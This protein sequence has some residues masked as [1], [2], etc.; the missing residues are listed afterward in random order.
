[1]VEVVVD[2]YEELFTSCQPTNFSDLI[3]VVQQK[4]TTSMNQWLTRDF[5]K[6]K[7]RGALKQMY[8]LKVPG[9][10]GMPPLFF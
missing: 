4:V 10:D 1:M 9:P 7:V 8:L 5:T 3:Q 2:Y 6:L